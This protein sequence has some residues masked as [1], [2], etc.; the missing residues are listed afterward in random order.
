MTLAQDP[1]ALAA[2]TIEAA[3]LP[4][5]QFNMSRSAYYQADTAAPYFARLRQD[6]PVHYCAESR[7]GPYWSITRHEDMM[8]VDAHHELFS[9][10]GNITIDEQEEE[11]ELPM[12]IA[13]DRPKHDAQRKTVSPVVAPSNLKTM[14]SLIRQRV[15]NILDSLPL[16]ETFDWVPRVAVDLTTQML[17]TLLDFPLEQRERLTRWSN[18]ASTGPGGGFVETREQR[19]QELLECLDCFVGLWNERVKRPPGNDL[20][21][22]LAHGKNTQNMPPMEYLGNLILLI[23]GGNDTT[24]NSISGGLLALN[25]YPDEFAK[26]RED[27]SLIPNMVA[28]IIRWQTPL[29]HMRRQAVDDVE[30]HGKTIRKGDKVV[31]WYLSGNRDETVFT[32]AETLQIDRHNARSHVSFG[33]GI[34]RC[35]GN[36]LAE[37]QLR[38][39]WEELL[40]RFSAIEVQ[41]PPTRVRSNLLRGIAE[42]PVRLT[43]A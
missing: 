10:A 14:E 32:D 35:M 3:S 41:A 29:V 27:P 37:M 33:Y 4:L 2:A 34:H 40:P 1:Q 25:R 43:A 20:I 12:F 13:M 5:N 19:K 11:F 28:E 6:D 22:M 42:M 30:L 18:V 17:A 9:S 39:L 21:S 38:I 31:M 26:L 8:W 24:R 16:N 36:R 15:C 7:F 23:V